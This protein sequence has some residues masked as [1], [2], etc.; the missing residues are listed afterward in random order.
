M[1]SRNKNF[2][3]SN[4]LNSDQ[5]P[6]ISFERIGEISPA[7]KTEPVMHRMPGL[8]VAKKAFLA[9]SSKVSARKAS[10][11]QFWAQM[12]NNSSGFAALGLFIDCAKITLV[13]I[14]ENSWNM[15]EMS[16]SAI[17]PKSNTLG[18]SG[19]L[20]LIVRTKAAADAPL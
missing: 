8:G 1:V 18:T 16:L 15:P 4:W 3:K 13:N 10:P 6:D 11:V 14:P 20:S 7:R 12:S 17:A 2:K 5:S 19:K 9:A